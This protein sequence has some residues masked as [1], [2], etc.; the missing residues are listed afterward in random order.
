MI[1]PRDVIVSLVALII[2]ITMMTKR[3][4]VPSSIALPASAKMRHRRRIQEKALPLPGEGGAC[5]GD[6]L[7]IDPAGDDVGDKMGHPSRARCARPWRRGPDEQAFH[8]S[9]QLGMEAAAWANHARG[10]RKATGD[11]GGFWKELKMGGGKR[12][13]IL[14]G[15][16]GGTNTRLAIIEIVK[17]HFHFLAEQTFPSREELSLESALRKFL[18]SNALHPITQAC[19][20]VAGPVAMVAV[21]PPI[22]PG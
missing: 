14:V 9:R 10:V 3:K 16:I 13:A 1:N 18:S 19:L 22:C 2:L 6:P 4:G 17:G 15:D 5:G 20:G 11:N 21:R 7:G 8:R 12:S